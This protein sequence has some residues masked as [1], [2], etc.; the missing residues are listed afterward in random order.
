MKLLLYAALLAST[1]TDLS[2]GHA[3]WHGY[4]VN[5]KVYTFEVYTGERDRWD[6]NITDSPPLAPGKALRTAREFVKRVPFPE[7]M[8]G[9]DSDS[10]TLKLM[11][12]NPPEWIYVI[13]FNGR[14]VGNWN[15]PVPWI[16]VPVRM[17][18][19]IPEPKITSK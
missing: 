14:P 8:S 16:D 15:G 13:R 1:S 7:T 6:P 12:Q 4:P 5:D 2:A 9:W 19:T 18:N 3:D 17:D 11:S 10:L